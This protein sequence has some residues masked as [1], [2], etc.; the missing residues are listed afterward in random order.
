MRNI[1]CNKVDEIYLSRIWTRKT[2]FDPRVIGE[3][4]KPSRDN[5]MHTFKMFDDEIQ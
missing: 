3:L 5:A 1:E 2:T 4:T